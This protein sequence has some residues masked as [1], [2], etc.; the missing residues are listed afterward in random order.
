MLDIA[1]KENRKQITLLHIPEELI[2]FFSTGE[3]L[4]DTESQIAEEAKIDFDNSFDLPPAE[5]LQQA[6][7][8]NRLVDPIGISD[9]GKYFYL[10][11][12][13]KN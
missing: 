4:S 5:E 1:E 12:E 9:D 6:D 13:Q 3:T 7:W 11:P 2:G 10:P 8:L